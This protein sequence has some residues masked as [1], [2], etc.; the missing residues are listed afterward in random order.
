MKKIMLFVAVCSLMLSLIG[1]GKQ[2]EVANISLMMWDEA[3][4]PV[5]Q[6]SIDKFNEKNEGKIVASIELVPWDTYWTKLD[7]S[8]ETKESADVMWMN[9]YLPKYATAEVVRPLDEYIEKDKLDLSQYIEGR[10]NAYNIDGK[11]YALPKG[12][13]TVFV[14]YNKEIF[15]RYGVEYPQEGWTWDDMRTIAAQLRDKISEAGGAEY[16]IV[17][18]LDDQPSWMNFVVQNGGNYISEDGKTTGMGMDESVEAIQN[19]VDLMKEE[20]MAP[21]TVLS[22]TKGTDLFVSGQGGLVFIGS[23]KASVL[24]SST[25]GADGNIGLIQM[26]ALNGSNSSVLGGLGYCLS[27]SSKHPKEAW[28]LIKYITSEESLYNEAVNGIDIPAHAK[29]Q[30]GYVKN[31]KNLDAQVILDA[32]VTGFPYQSNG[33]FEWTSYVNDAVQKALSQIA[34]VKETL[35]EGASQAQAVL[36]E[37]YK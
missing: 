33:N 27:A 15:D 12:L 3:Q 7:A 10:V 4:S 13:D 29:A 1:C 31:F 18:E 30:E 23:W 25:L 20:L 21:Y 22:E 26:P 19:M 17:M 24:E 2:N 32:S 14:A 16:P 8:L 28:E 9:V 11:Q 37:L 6:Q 34:P 35:V 36:D 5:I